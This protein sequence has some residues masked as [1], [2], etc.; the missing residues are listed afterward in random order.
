MATAEMSTELHDKYIVMMLQKLCKVRSSA[1]QGSPEGKFQRELLEVQSV[2]DLVRKLYNKKFIAHHRDGDG[3]DFFLMNSSE[4]ARELAMTLTQSARLLGQDVHFERI[5]IAKAEVYGIIYNGV[6]IW[7][8]RVPLMHEATEMIKDADEVTNALDRKYWQVWNRKQEEPKITQT[9]SFSRTRPRR[10]QEEQRGTSSPDLR[11]G[12]RTAIE[13][14][15]ADATIQDE[16]V[17]LNETLY[18]ATE[19]AEVLRGIQHRHGLNIT[20]P[21]VRQI[22]ML[23]VQAESKALED[24]DHTTAGQAREIRRRA[25]EQVST[26]IGDA[27]AEG[28]NFIG[29][30]HPVRTKRRR[31]AIAPDGTVHREITANRAPASSIEVIAE[32]HAPETFDFGTNTIPDTVENENLEDMTNEIREERM[33]LEDERAILQTLRENMSQ[34]H[35]EML[36]LEER[37]RKERLSDQ[38]ERDDNRELIQNLLAEQSARQERPNFSILE[39]P[40]Q[41]EQ[42][43][44]HQP[45][46]ESTRL[47]GKIRNLEDDVFEVKSPRP[48]PKPRTRIPSQTG[49]GN[50]TLGISSSTLT[51]KIQKAP[52]I[53]FTFSG[54]KKMDGTESDFE[55]LEFTLTNLEQRYE[56]D[57]IKETLIQILSGPALKTVRALGDATYA[58]IKETLRSSF[59]LVREPDCDATKV[60]GMRQD[61]DEDLSSFRTRLE[62]GVAEWEASDDIVVFTKDSREK[63]LKRRFLWGIRENLRMALSHLADRSDVGFQEVFD[64]ARRK[65]TQNALRREQNREANRRRD[66][67]ASSTSTQ[68]STG[69]R[70]PAPTPRNLGPSP[71]PRNTFVP[72]P[73]FGGGVP[74]TVPTLTRDNFFAPPV[75]AMQGDQARIPMD[76]GHP[77]MAKLA[78]PDWDPTTNAP[79]CYAC[80]CYGHLKRECTPELAME[81][82]QRMLRRQNMLAA[83]QQGATGPAPQGFSG[84]PTPQQASSPQG[85]QAR[86][87][88]PHTTPP[89]GPVAAM[90]PRPP[91][92]LPTPPRM[93][94]NA[95][96][97]RSGN[98]QGAASN[99]LQLSQQATQ[100]RK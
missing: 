99:G 91:G 11:E 47:D 16:S 21:Q 55:Q 76:P 37:M 41:E 87:P 24:T 78:L 67:A 90:Q 18:A 80:G 73:P 45:R 69:A 79:R 4:S 3:N 85:F 17:A 19:R 51:K 84:Q 70:G 60:F 93:V 13:Q 8:S 61:S 82:Q 14:P 1:V 68:A 100:Q 2:R 26:G 88:P 40:R 71:A 64:A 32:V 33:K 92:L 39:E 46:H 25:R 59:G 28:R 94:G 48:T 72:R 29:E 23:L 35:E 65:E 74:A 22:E 53:N 9:V 97:Y 38:K 58:R 56:E 83:G 15:S 5:P 89:S 86:G 77:M 96:Q 27:I 36:H 10:S 7:P 44:T 62:A 75:A 31:Q 66:S 6:R 57:A 34:R 52:K 81:Y 50:E 42:E 49:G 98:G 30:S 20:T 43:Q 63:L 12:N 54:V 95:V